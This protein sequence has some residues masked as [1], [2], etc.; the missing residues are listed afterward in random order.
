V[1]GTTDEYGETLKRQNP[2]FI[3]VAR[4]KVVVASNRNKNVP[5]SHHWIRP[6]CWAAFGAEI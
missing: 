6:V 5:R 4:P 1:A 2:S 3:G